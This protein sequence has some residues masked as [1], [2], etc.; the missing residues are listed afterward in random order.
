LG[1]AGGGKGA[2]IDAILGAGGG[3]V[4]VYVQGRNDLDLGRESEVIIRAGEPVNTL[5]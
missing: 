1:S 4:S 3:A 2:A 5:R